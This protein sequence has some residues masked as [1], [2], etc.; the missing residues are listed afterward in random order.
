[1]DSNNKIFRTMSYSKS[2]FGMSIVF[3]ILTIP[4]A[5][6]I[7]VMGT[8]SAMNDAEMWQ[9]FL[10]GFLVI[11]GIPILLL[12]TSIVVLILRKRINGKRS[13]KSL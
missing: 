5:Y 2:F 8:D 10:F 1:M 11:Q 9:G 13:K 4:M 7:G 6:F 12:I 3:N